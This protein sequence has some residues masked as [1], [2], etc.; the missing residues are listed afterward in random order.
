MNLE[1]VALYP[2]LTASLY[3]LSCQA[4]I[5]SWLWERYPAWLDSFLR[6]AACSGFWWGVLVHALFPR[7]CLTLPAGHWKTYLVVGLCSL[8]WTPFMAKILLRDLR[9]IGG[10]GEE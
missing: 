2:L 6:C 8:W 9:Y 5:T 1:I 3:Y 4:V 7:P 10:E